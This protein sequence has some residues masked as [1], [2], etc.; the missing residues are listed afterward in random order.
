MGRSTVAELITSGQAQNSYNNSGINTNALWIDAFNRALRDLVEDIGLVGSTTIDYITG[1]TE[2]DL[3]SDFFEV[4]QVVDAGNY[5]I[6]K[7]QF[8]IE[9]YP[10]ANSY[11]IKDIGSVYK[12]VFDERN[13]DETLTINYIRYPALLSV[14]NYLSQKPE[15]PTVGEDAL[16]FFALD[17]ALRN[18]N[19]P[20]QAQEMEQKYERERKKI[21]DAKYRAM[22]GW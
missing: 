19:Q 5:P 3:P 20:G 16:I 7:R 12:I 18:N 21:R 8:E 9:P 10:C 17:K 6:R 4:N 13:S 1:T 22:A 15:V 11:Y 2:Y 14:A